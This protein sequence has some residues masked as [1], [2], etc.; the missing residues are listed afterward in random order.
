MDI[1]DEFAMD[2]I[3]EARLAPSVHNVQPTRWRL[4]D[5]HLSVL[6][7]QS[8]AIP[9]AD[10][11]G[12]DWL[13]SIGASV[14][15]L[16]IALASRGLRLVDAVRAETTPQP[17]RPGLVEVAEL[18]ISAHDAGP[19]PA[20][21]VSARASWRGGFR[22]SDPETDQALDRLDEERDD[23]VLVRDRVTI[24]RIVAMADESGLY[25]LRQ[26]DHR[27]ELVEWM[28]LSD[29]HPRYHLDGLNSEAMNLG[30][31]DA[32][33]A[34]LVLGPLFPALDRIGLA[35]PLV[36]ESG[37]TVSAAAI[38]LFHRPAGESAFDSGRA[39]Y[40]A[41]L[42]M[43]RAGLRGC[44]M[45]VLADRDVTRNWLERNA[46]VPEGRRIVSV[47]RIGVPTRRLAIRHAR[48]PTQDLL[49]RQRPSG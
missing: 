49:I 17:G 10:P 48:L 13:L 5:G 34:G 42:A 7:D 36:S 32:F 28:R 29:R 39:F 24:R 41:W 44:P 15:G 8:R 4:D 6:G 46:A 3:D 18:A 2:L 20:E 22:K 11:S 37:K 21:P 47:F 26:A 14:E 25:F 38:A 27:R 43:E 9:V 16:A 35:A 40:R 45:S 12:R 30:R 33:G 31:L 1:S 23:L 19:V